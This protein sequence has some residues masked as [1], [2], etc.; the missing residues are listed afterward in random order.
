MNDPSARSRRLPGWPWILLALMAAL[1]G[2]YVVDF[3][4]DVD[5]E[6]PAV[7]RPT[8]NRLPSPAYRLAEPG[9]TLDRVGIYLTAG[10]VVVGAFSWLGAVVR[11]RSGRLRLAATVLSL[12]GFW[13]AANPGPTFDG[14]HG[15]GWRTAFDPSAPWALRM[16]LAVAAAMGVALVAWACRG[17]DSWGRLRESRVA[18]L[19]TGSVV[20]ALISQVGLPRVEPA[21]YWQRWAFVGAL[22]LWLIALFRASR[23]PV[24][25]PR[26][27]VIGLLGAAAWVGLVV[28]GIDLSWY[29]RP[30][31]RLR[32]VEPGRIYISAMPTY[33]GLRVAHARHH[34]KTIVNLFPESKLGQ[35][36]RLADEV[37]FA[38]EQGIRYV[39]S[40]GDVASSDLFLDETLRLA[41]D[42]S[43]WPILIHCHACMDRSPAWMGI[44]RFVVQGRPLREIFQEIE[45]HRGY[46]PKASV[47][48][49]YNRVLAP[50]APGRYEADP[51]ATLLR[52]CAAGTRD[53][54]QATATREPAAEDGCEE[55]TR[56]K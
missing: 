46:R 42:P 19:V 53:P 47:I 13:Y 22:T 52:Q 45:G 38:R 25:L 20:L 4:D 16:I 30:L 8:F 14:W 48:L 31:E 15:W 50:R 6:Y 39:E 10:G 28:L 12:L 34:F 26:R 7:T 49:L 24:P 21:G 56:R 35:S 9:D 27:L 54:F 33:R 18:G 51:T 23:S 2:W 3:E 37:R 44:Y 36:P 32:I 29:H 43:A 11:G 5:P 41:Q 1:A 17:Q 40:L 55:T